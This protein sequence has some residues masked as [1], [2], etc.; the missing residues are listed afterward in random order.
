MTSYAD[1]GRGTGNERSS[2]EKEAHVEQRGALDAR[3]PAAPPL[4]CS[5]TAQ[6]T[7]YPACPCAY[8]VRLV[9]VPHKQREQKH[10]QWAGRQGGVQRGVHQHPQSLGTLA[11]GSLARL[12]AQLRKAALAVSGSLDLLLTGNEPPPEMCLGWGGGN[13]S[14]LLIALTLF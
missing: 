1:L 9:P 14:H 13:R 10:H 2:L 3:S 5:G 7:V 8:A 4:L 12:L 6:C 11:L